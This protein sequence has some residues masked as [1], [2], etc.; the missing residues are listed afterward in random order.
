[1]VGTYLTMNDLAP[2][3]Q[4]RWRGTRGAFVCLM[5][6]AHLVG[7]AVGAVH[8]RSGGGRCPGYP[9]VQDLIHETLVSLMETARR[10]SGFALPEG[11]GP[12]DDLAPWLFRVLKNRATDLVRRAVAGKRAGGVV[13]VPIDDLHGIGVPGDSGGVDVKVDIER[14]HATVDTLIE[15]GAPPTHALA[16]MALN[17][18][19]RVRRELVERATVPDPRGHPDKVH[20]LAREPAETWERLQEWAS[21]HLADPAGNAARLHLAWIL[22]SRDRTTP[23]AWRAGAFKE[24]RDARDTLRQWA[25]RFQARLVAFVKEER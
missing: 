18:P 17:F 21:Q 14:L 11:T 16:W 4:G 8:R 2:L 19:R 1:M 3:L 5:R 6:Q 13:H 9:E 23:E 15:R 25:T 22:R 20:G 24:A 10:K 12:E 7:L